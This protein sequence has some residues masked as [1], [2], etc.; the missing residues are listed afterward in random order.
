M[1]GGTDM[2]AIRT[3][4]IR[5]LQRADRIVCMEQRHARRVK[6]M[7]FDQEDI[8]DRIEVWGIPDDYEYC[9]PELIDI[10]RLKLGVKPKG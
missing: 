10:I 4:T 1:S 5:D 8:C 2:D 9:Q 3:V 7:A 6:S